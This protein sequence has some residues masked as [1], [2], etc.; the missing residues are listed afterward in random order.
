M[1]TDWVYDEFDGDTTPVVAPPVSFAPATLSSSQTHV[2]PDATPRKTHVVPDATP[3]QTHVVPDVTPRQT[4]VGVHTP[5]VRQAAV[6]P[7]ATPVMHTYT[8]PTRQASVLPPNHL[9]SSWTLNSVVSQPPLMASSTPVKPPRSRPVSTSA[10]D[11]P[12]AASPMRPSRSSSDAWMCSDRNCGVS[13]NDWVYDDMEAQPRPPKAPHKPPSKSRLATYLKDAAIPGAMTE[14]RY[15]AVRAPP[16]L[17]GTSC[18]GEVSWNDVG[19]GSAHSTHDY[20]SCMS[21]THTD[22]GHAVC[23]DAYSTT[24][25]LSTRVSDC[26]NEYLSVPDVFRYVTLGGQLSESD[27]ID[28]GRTVRD[29]VKGQYYG[30]NRYIHITKRSGFGPWSRTSSTT[31]IKILHY[32]MDD[33]PKMAEACLKWYSRNTRKVFY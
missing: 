30:A 24:Q 27:L 10:V 4:S 15:T 25:S 26:G 12:V 9:Q 6:V 29:T 19:G 28:L 32:T 13:T 33:Y 8:P 20:S 16:T 7:D 3:S 5:P 18:D 21:G 17:M 1:N 11:T 14:T 2:A 31:R 23:S 22:S